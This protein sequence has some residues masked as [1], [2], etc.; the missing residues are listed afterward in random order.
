MTAETSGIV[1]RWICK[2]SLT[3]GKVP[4]GYLVSNH[5][6]WISLRRCAISSRYKVLLPALLHTVL[7][8]PACNEIRS[9]HTPLPYL[10][11]SLPLLL[12]P[13][14]KPQPNGENIPIGKK[15]NKLLQFPPVGAPPI[16][17][18][19]N[20]SLHNFLL[21]YSPINLSNKQSA[22][23]VNQSINQSINPL[24]PELYIHPYIPLSK[25]SLSC[26][27]H[28]PTPRPTPSHPGSYLPE[29]RRR[30]ERT[31]H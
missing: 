6:L 25:L 17:H 7:C 28:S 19:R 20:L 16:Q 18:L 21:C 14:S 12:C 24:P 9:N 29:L 2:L 1:P 13:Q 30:S 10:I 31:R 23:S 11:P 8:S 3:S 4:F 22:R 15:F 26:P 5:G 27:T